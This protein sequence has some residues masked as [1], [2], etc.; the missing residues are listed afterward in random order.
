MAGSETPI[1][2]KTT[3][4]IEESKNHATHRLSLPSRS[5]SPPTSKTQQEEPGLVRP[6]RLNTGIF[7]NG[8]ATIPSIFYH[9]NHSFGSGLSFGN[10]VGSGLSYQEEKNN[11]GHHTTSKTAEKPEKASVTDE[12]M[13]TR[14]SVKTETKNI[15]N[16][17]LSGIPRQWDDD[18]TPDLA[19]GSMPGYRRDGTRVDAANCDDSLPVLSDHICPFDEPVDDAA[20]CD[21]SLPFDESVD[22]SMPN[23]PRGDR[24]FEADESGD[25]TPPPTQDR[26]R[27]RGI[28]RNRGFWVPKVW[29]TR[30]SHPDSVEAKWR[31]KRVWE[32]QDGA[33]DNSEEPEF[34]VAQRD[35]DAGLWPLMGVPKSI[36]VLTVAEDID[37]AKLDGE[38]PDDKKPQEDDSSNLDDRRH[39]KVQKYWD[40]DG[41]IIRHKQN[42][43]AREQIV[44]SSILWSSVFNPRLLGKLR[45]ALII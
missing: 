4:K 45:I 42:G 24:R 23:I 5:T 33:S 25:T 30:A 26:H 9:S 10:S 6:G 3:S 36:A 41:D 12:K 19:D 21:D 18:R 31:V 14:F 43:C 38:D 15:E 17:S 27:R 22:E 44:L 1:T 39:W 37:S 20:N 40:V 28:S 29:L 34:G 2:G 32:E 16:P 8:N 35:L 13:K 7:D 11:D